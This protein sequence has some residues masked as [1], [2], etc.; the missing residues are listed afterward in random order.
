MAKEQDSLDSV[1]DAHAAL[2]RWMQ[3]YGDDVWSFIFACVRRHDVA[4]DLTQEVFVRAFT[5]ASQFRGDSSVKTWLFSIA[6]NLVRDRSRSAFFRRVSLQQDME[7]YID[8]RP[9]QSPSARA[10]IWDTILE[11]KPSYREVIVLRLREE[12]TFAEIS[13]I[14]G[15]SEGTLRVRYQRALNQVRRLLGEEGGSHCE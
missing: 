8:I 14:T 6:R 12:M 7:R 3:T 10:A 13:T 11:L 2:T 5:H 15:V 4:D 9:D 1:P